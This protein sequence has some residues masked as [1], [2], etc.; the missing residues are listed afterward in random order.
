M[1]INNKK[2]ITP[3]EINY[4]NKN[5]QYKS[6][7]Y[8][9]MTEEMENNIH[10]INNIQY[11]LDVTYYTTPPT[12]NKNK[13]FVILSFNKNRFCTLLFNLSLNFFFNRE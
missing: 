12:K 6:I 3:L 5:K 9:I 8:I 7:S 11:F 4:N 13:L 1:T 2:I 10:E